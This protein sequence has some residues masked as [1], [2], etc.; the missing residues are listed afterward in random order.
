M[1]LNL[2]DAM[3]SSG[4]AADLDLA[5]TPDEKTGV[6]E[7]EEGGGGNE[8]RGS[9]GGGLPCVAS[10]EE[11]FSSIPK[12]KNGRATQS[13][14]YE[15]ACLG[16]LGCLYFLGFAASHGIVVIAPLLLKAIIGRTL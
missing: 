8:P 9:A 1:Q 10:F 7:S 4:S 2:V 15:F 13:L 16:V 14:P 12:R 5:E 11:I 6:A 3:P